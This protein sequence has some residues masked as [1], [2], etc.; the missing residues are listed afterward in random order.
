MIEFISAYNP[1]LETA[2]NKRDKLIKSSEEGGSNKVQEF[3][4]QYLGFIVFLQDNQKF[5]I[6]QLVYEWQAF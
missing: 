3:Q 2:Q 6:K 5:M 4:K 1:L